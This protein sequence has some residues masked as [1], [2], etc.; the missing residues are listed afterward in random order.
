[1]YYFLNKNLLVSKLTP[2]IY[3]SKKKKTLTN[4]NI[5][6]ANEKGTLAFQS[7]QHLGHPKMEW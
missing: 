1:M 7:E 3:L 2:I 5:N 6:K 4:F